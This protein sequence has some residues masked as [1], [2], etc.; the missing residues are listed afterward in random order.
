MY[1]M[2]GQQ[3]LFEDNDCGCLAAERHIEWQAT[4]GQVLPMN[5]RMSGLLGRIGA[6]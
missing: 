3:T 1:G 5:S 4:S 6:S 2:E